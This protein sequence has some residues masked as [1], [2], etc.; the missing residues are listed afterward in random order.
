V[1][2]AAVAAVKAETPEVEAVAKA[3]A[4]AVEDAVEAALVA[5][6]L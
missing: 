5:R 6:G 2:S 1:A 4:K 3:A